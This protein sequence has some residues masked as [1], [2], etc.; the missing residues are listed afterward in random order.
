[1]KKII[2]VV[3]SAAML[4]ACATAPDKIQASYVSPIQYSAYD[5]DQIRAELLRVSGRVREV[6]GAQ[7]RQSNNDAWAMGVGLVLFW[8]ALFFL[9]GGSD[10][11]EELARLKG[12]Y[13]AL[14]QAAIQKKCP[15]AQ[16]IRSGRGG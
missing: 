8:P 6:A 12:D 15:V 10:R 13:D 14:E 16:E 4:T 1:M 5:C 7:K 3:L 2:A 11:K 9:A